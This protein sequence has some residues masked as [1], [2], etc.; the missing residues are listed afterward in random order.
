VL[1]RVHAGLYRAGNLVRLTPFYQAM[2][3]ALV[4][5][6]PREVEDPHVVV[7][8][9]GTHAPTAFDQAFLA[10]RL[11]F[12]LV[13]GRDLVV[14]D[15]RVWLRSVDRLEPVDVIFRHVISRATDPLELQAG[16]RLG[17]AGL[18]EV[19]RRGAV[20]VVNALG[21]GVLENLALA[22]FDDR[23]CRALLDEP[24]RLRSF[25]TWWCGDPSAR[26]R[27]LTG[28]ADLRVVHLPTGQTWEGPLL[29]ADQRASL[30]DRIDTHP[31]AYAGQQPMPLSTT[32]TVVRGELAAERFHLTTY[33]I[34]H[35]ATYA[36]LPGGLGEVHEDPQPTSPGPGG[37][38]GRPTKDLWIVQGSD[39]PAAGESPRDVVDELIPGNLAM[40]PRVLDDLYWMG[41]YAE[42]A[43][44][45]VRLIAATHHVLVETNMVAGPGS[46]ADVLLRALF[47]QTGTPRP[48]A[49]SS[50]LRQLRR[51]LI[52][53]S[54]RGTVARSLA[55]L[56]YAADGVRDQLSHDVWVVLAGA[57]RALAALRRADPEDSSRLA[58]T[59][60]AGLVSLLAL[61]GITAENMVRD[62][63]WQLLDAGRGVERAIQ[64]VGLLRS[65]LTMPGRGDGD[66]DSPT[67]QMV[68]TA[69][70]TAAESIVTHRRRHG[71]R[72][73][74]AT[75][76]DLLVADVANPRSVA[77]QVA[78]IR[79]ALARLPHAPANGRPQRLLD[80]LADLTSVAAVA[81]VSD[82][83]TT[84]EPPVLASIARADDHL[85]EV[86]HRLHRLSDA[87]S[88]AYL[89]PEPEPQP[90]WVVADLPIGPAGGGM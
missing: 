13:E 55:R 26:S 48:A 27:V 82:V 36:T 66:W 75:V 65:G 24:L 28:L 8:T 56:S 76:L 62:S 34:R 63:G 14:Q 68:L 25:P 21:A 6:G 37:L 58:D 41:R 18:T 78:R 23:I 89:R 11:G 85:A 83:E 4:E 40:V 71:G 30:A 29:S 22:A 46:A 15:G 74:L 51:L 72:T 70:L 12:P 86:R 43:E 44:D 42:R 84:V 9:P 80:E 77:F 52:D 64:V 90:M 60:A 19:V 10:S 73:E 35:G 81:R 79:A 87:I 17:V 5:A 45:T 1:S 20:S 69:V 67:N 31:Y 53:W 47:A 38:T 32:P 57:E 88:E 59:A 7:L 49:G 54:Q 39:V 61:N 50:G 2:R 16:S 3:A 33:L